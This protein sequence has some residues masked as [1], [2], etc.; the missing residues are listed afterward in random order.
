MARKVQRSRKTD[1]EAPRVQ[2]IRNARVRLKERV[3]RRL[4]EDLQT[5]MRSTLYKT[6]RSKRRITT[7]KTMPT[8][9]LRSSRLRWRKAPVP[10]T[11]PRRHLLSR[12][13]LG[14]LLG[15][16]IITALVGFSGIATYRVASAW[17]QNKPVTL[18][19]VTNLQG[20]WGE[21]TRKKPVKKLRRST[22][23]KKV[24]KRHARLA[25]ARKMIAKK[26]V[27]N[28]ARRRP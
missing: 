19:T 6:T 14:Y 21:K 24:N 1:A 9:V 28:T 2:Q 17:F 3:E 15:T 13:G 7:G 26:K 16:L 20:L 8:P 27:R 18:S 22:S 23:P 25:H 5:T 12:R 4:P 10:M 11:R